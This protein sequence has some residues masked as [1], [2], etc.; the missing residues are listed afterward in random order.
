MPQLMAGKAIVLAP[1]PLASAKEALHGSVGFSAHT[2]FPD[3]TSMLAAGV[4]VSSVRCLAWQQQSG[5]PM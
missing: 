5:T 2:H 3:C 4:T 1:M